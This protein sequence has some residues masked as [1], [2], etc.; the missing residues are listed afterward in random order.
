MA[1]LSAT[2][3]EYRASMVSNVNDAQFTEAEIPGPVQSQIQAVTDY[4]VSVHNLD[5][6]IAASCVIRMSQLSIN[7]FTKIHNSTAY[8]RPEVISISNSDY[9]SAVMAFIL[10]HELSHEYT[11]DI[12][13]YHSFREFIASTLPDGYSAYPAE[14]LMFHYVHSIIDRQNKRSLPSSELYTFALLRNDINEEETSD[15]AHRYITTMIDT[16]GLSD[17][18]RVMTALPD[19]YLHAR[20]ELLQ[21]IEPTTI[22]VLLTLSQKKVETSID[23]LDQIVQ[24]DLDCSG[25]VTQP[26][27]DE[28]YDMIRVINPDRLKRLIQ[29]FSACIVTSDKSLP[30]E[31]PKK[32]GILLD[33]DL[34]RRGHQKLHLSEGMMLQNGMQIVIEPIIHRYAWY[35]RQKP[36]DL[37][38]KSSSIE[39]VRNDELVRI[40]PVTYRDMS[41]LLYNLRNQLA[42]SSD[43]E[44]AYNNF[45][46]Y[47]RLAYHHKLVLYNEANLPVTYLEMSDDEK[48]QYYEDTNH[49][50]IR[51]MITL[52]NA[53]TQKYPDDYTQVI[54]HVER[55]ITGLEN[56]LANA[57]ILILYE[58][59]GIGTQ[60]PEGH[61]E[62]T[63][64]TES[65]F[66][67]L[68]YQAKMNVI[69]SMTTLVKH[70]D[71]TYSQ[72]LNMLSGQ[73][74][75]QVFTDDE[76]RVI[77]YLQ[78]VLTWQEINSPEH[79]AF[80][81]GE[82]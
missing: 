4:F 78:N 28:I 55:I 40:A 29:S 65:E 77:S 67:P 70:A 7:G 25:H 14:I 20:P 30:S 21:Y 39:P 9:I 34:E 43:K 12:L 13:P 42:H 22:E 62:I 54:S 19:N 6:E 16:L 79:L 63:T 15:R 31:I 2:T 74:F 58:A 37:Y 24:N 68:P 46:A 61:P 41:Y 33:I 64:A 17:F 8:R 38:V 69:N 47:L 49:D 81:L 73:S 51:M 66:L 71:C 52:D 48:R 10:E 36:E 80:V 32:L 18:A 60:E 50:T 59:F 53:L 76:R 1:M 35:C 75:S 56:N 11:N 3:D 45:I 57:H 23:I 44:A 72:A 5:P 26:W 82:T 27:T